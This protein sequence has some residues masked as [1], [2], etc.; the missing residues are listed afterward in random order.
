LFVV[1][2]DIG[3]C[4]CVF[5]LFVSPSRS[6]PRENRCLAVRALLA[7]PPPLLLLLLLC[8]L[9][10]ARPA[11]APAPPRERANEKHDQNRFT[12]RKKFFH[13][14]N[15]LH[16][17]ID[18]RFQAVFV[19]LLE[20]S[21]AASGNHARPHLDAKRVNHL[22]PCPQSVHTQRHS[23]CLFVCVLHALI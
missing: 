17:S 4:V 6:S 23:F 10:C 16:M 13:L 15:L 21:S 20:I 9:S 5:F 3:V 7:L 18:D 22:V 1:G 19:A 8:R 11:L 14:R 12:L 2:S